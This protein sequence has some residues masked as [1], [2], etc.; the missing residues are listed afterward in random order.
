MS[1]IVEKGKQSAE[2]MLAQAKHDIEVQ[3]NNAR[4][5]LL[6]DVADLAVKVVQKFVVTEV[7]E[8]DKKATIDKLVEQV[9]Q[10]N[11]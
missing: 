8:K 6:K 2:Q 4:K 1:S 7:P 11:G 9:A 5:T 3:T 10:N